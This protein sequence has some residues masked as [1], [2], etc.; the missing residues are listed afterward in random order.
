MAEYVEWFVN[1]EKQRDGFLKLVERATPKQVMLVVAASEMGKTWL[2][3]R[4]RHE[5]R[6]RSVGVSVVDFRD[7]RAWDYLALVRQ[8]RDQFDPVHFNELTEVINATTGVNVTVS[9]GAG[10]GGVDLNLATDGGSVSGSTVT[11]GDVAGRDIIKDNFFFVQ[12]DSTAAR[13]AIE[14]RITDTFFA[15]LRRM[16]AEKVA[17]FLFDSYEDV[18]DEADRWIRT[19]L[20]AQIRDGL[21]PRVIVVK[22]GRA[23][24]PEYDSSWRA[25]VAQT[26]LTVFEEIHIAEYI[27]Q[28]RKLIDLDLQTIL[29]TSGGH[30]GLLGRMADIAALEND[31]DNDDNW[32]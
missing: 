15:C 21:L 11:V 13:H 3:Q 2:I 20:M 26:D 25:V 32:L 30:P 9:S 12:A 14:N 29:R 1:R 7:R 10:A 18:T 31:D 8:F 24:D 4:L 5:C 19:N 22:A 27:T 28:R 16:T 23:I 6:T 17:V